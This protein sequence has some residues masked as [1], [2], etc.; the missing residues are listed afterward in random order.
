MANQSIHDAFA[1]MWT[2]VK[3]KINVVATDLNNYKSHTHNYAGSSSAG[4]PANSANILNTS[5]KMDYGWN[6][7]NYFNLSGTAGSAAKA[8]DTPTTAWWHILRLNHSNSNGYYTDL[9]IPFN[10]DSIYW[11]TIRNGSVAYSQWVKVLD[12]KNYSTYIVPKSGGTF[13]G[14]ITVKTSVWANH[15]GGECQV[16]VHSSAT[17]LYLWGNTSTGTRGM[18]QSGGVNGYVIQ[19]TDSGNTFYGNLTGNAATAT[20]AT[21]S[22]KLD[23]YH[24]SSSATA[25][26]YVLRDGNN[27]AFFGY[28]NSAIGNNENP[29]VSQ[30]IVTNGS[31]NFFRKAS[32][33]H[34]RNAMSAMT[35]VNKNSHYGMARPDGTDTVWIRTTSQGLIPYQSG[36]KY[37]GTCSIGTSSWYFQN[38]YCDRLHGSLL[39]GKTG[40]C[41]KVSEDSNLFGPYKSYGNVVHDNSLALG[42]SD[43][44]WSKVYAG[45]SSISTS[46]EREKNIIGKIDGKYKDLFMKLEPILFVWDRPGKYE[47]DYVH[48]G[49]GAQTTEKHARE[50]GIKEWEIAAIEHTYFPENPEDHRTDRYGMAYEE[51]HMLTM[52]VVQDNVKKIAKLEYENELLKQRLEALENK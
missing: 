30:I 2:H 15:D 50:C 9:A 5:S 12:E 19:C 38:L 29:G 4:G 44:R 35:A 47:D 21:N 20:T 22:D 36:A 37:S 34:V 17:N 31:D 28:I 25:S 27:H 10:H 1:Q 23:G 52:A 46:D 26:T 18:Y 41:V 49:L 7:L 24:G 3:A 32:A 33:A 45:S 13:T 11:K 42:Y 40:E 8:N 6:G 39:G 48:F 14:G 51:I 16:G 43:K